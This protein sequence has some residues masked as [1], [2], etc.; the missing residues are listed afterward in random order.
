MCQQTGYAEN[1]VWGFKI[2]YLT[3]TLSHPTD[4][5]FYVTLHKIPYNKTNI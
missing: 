1:N 4:I 5:H 2:K 3:V